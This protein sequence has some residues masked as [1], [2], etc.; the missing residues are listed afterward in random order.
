[1]EQ[2]CVPNEILR[3]YGDYWLVSWAPDNNGLD[4]HL[5]ALVLK[6]QIATHYNHLIYAWEDKM[7]KEKEQAEQIEQVALSFLQYFRSPLEPRLNP[8]RRQPGVK[9]DQDL[10]PDMTKH[11]GELH[12]CKNHDTTFNVCKGCRVAHHTMKDRSFDRKAIMAQGARAP[13]CKDCA[14]DIL[15]EYRRGYQGCV[16]DTEWTCFRCREIELARLCG[17]KESRHQEGRCGRCYGVGKE[18]VKHVVIC[19]YCHEFRTFGGL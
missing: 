19:L 5:P 4:V 11:W 1:M 13:V 2:Y 18:L 10:L 14:G 3:D 8:Y 17:A 9:C 12:H 15:S 16:C 6:S 7:R